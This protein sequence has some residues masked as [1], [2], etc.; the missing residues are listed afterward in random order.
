MRTGTHL[1]TEQAPQRA[2]SQCGCG[3]GAAA[4]SLLLGLRVD[5]SVALLLEQAE[6]SV[7]PRGLVPVLREALLPPR[8]L[9]SALPSPQSPPH[10]TDG[11]LRQR[12]HVALGGRARLGT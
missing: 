10:A 9:F 11:K 6:G 2:L 5:M 7:A 4:S 1:G 3:G 8:G 12:G